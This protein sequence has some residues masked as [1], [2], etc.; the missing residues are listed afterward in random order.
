MNTNDL[1]IWDSKNI[2]P[3]KYHNVILWNDLEDNTKFISLNQLVDENSNSLKKKY[4][5]Y[6]YE[7]GSHC[8]EN[9]ILKVKNKFSYWWMTSIVKKCSIEQSPHINDAIKLIALNSYIKKSKCRSINFFS[10]NQELIESVKLICEMSSLGFR[11]LN[12]ANMISDNIKSVIKS[13][14]MLRIKG[15]L[16]I[17]GYILKRLNFRKLG[18]GKWKKSNSKITLFSYLSGSEKTNSNK[19]WGSLP[20]ELKKNKFSINWL[21]LYVRNSEL[22]SNLKVLNHINMLNDSSQNTHVLI[23][24]FLDFRVMLLIF[25]DFFKFSIKFDRI[26][27]KSYQDKT[28]FS[29]LWPLISKDW[30]DS[31]Y[32]RNLANNVIYLNLFKRA[33]DTLDTQNIGVYLQENQGWEY[34]LLNSW[35][36]AGHK[37]II[38]YP[39]AVARFWDL[40]LFFDKRTYDRNNTF[41]LPLPDLMAVNGLFFKNLYKEGGFPIERLVN[42]EATR[43][44][45]L[46]NISIRDKKKSPKKIIQLLILGEYNISDTQ[47]LLDFYYLSK[48]LIK[49]P[50]DVILKPHPSTLLNYGDVSNLDYTLTNSPMAVVLS[51]VDIV[52]TGFHTAA[53]MEAYY[54]GLPIINLLSSS[55]LNMSPLYN[56][57]DVNFIRQPHEFARLLND[58]NFTKIRN[59]REINRIF[60]LNEDL[61]KW[62]KLLFKYL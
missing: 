32:G 13:K 19:Y 18:V 47:F 59:K 43:Y 44:Q 34:C 25:R 41:P 17:L 38:G 51:K 58:D 1:L 35:R 37:K 56:F 42:V 61:K 52:L 3:K 50:L 30:Y 53:S 5:K 22:D 45:H 49:V 2:P 28:H 24:S 40:R 9:E 7:L 54:Y 15:I 36:E 4:L 39:H 16:F 23:D 33:L 12:S 31:I 55:R 11:R 10:L 26:N 48:N 21:Y 27:I 20:Q 46:N 6:I 14:L 29:F 57:E 8:S 60:Y 62:R